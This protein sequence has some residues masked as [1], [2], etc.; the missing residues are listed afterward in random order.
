MHLNALGSLTRP[1]SLSA[2]TKGAMQ[3]QFENVHHYI[4]YSGAQ[5]QI[6]IVDVVNSLLVPLVWQKRL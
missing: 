5:F 2:Q 1:L 4:L 3:H 6:D